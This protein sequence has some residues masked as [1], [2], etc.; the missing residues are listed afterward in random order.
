MSAG[1]DPGSYAVTGGTGTLV[2]GHF[3]S[4]P[5][6]S[7]MAYSFNVD[8]GNGCGPI[9]I[10]GSKTCNCTTDAGTMDVNPLS[11]CE[12]SPFRYSFLPTVRSFFPILRS[13]PSK[14]LLRRNHLQ[15]SER[16]SQLSLLDTHLH[17]TPNGSQEH[18]CLTMTRNNRKH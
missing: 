16:S 14:P 11:D 7:G 9:V 3:T 10:A 4:D 2:A 18:A 15:I 5:I 12:A 6:T 17:V 8:D 1:G 13:V